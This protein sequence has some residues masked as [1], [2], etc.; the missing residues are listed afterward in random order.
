MAGLTM[1][2]RLEEIHSVAV[3]E[4]GGLYELDNGNF[5]QIP[6]DASSYLGEDPA[7][8]NPLIDWRQKTTPQAGF[9]GASV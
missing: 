4:A 7:M 6:A 2:R 8:C 9:D 1:A 5:T 3:I